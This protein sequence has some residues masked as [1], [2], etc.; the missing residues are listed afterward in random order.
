MRAEAAARARGFGTRKPLVL[1][2]LGIAVLA[3]GALGW[4]GYASIAGAVIASGH[5][6]VE[7]R[8]QVVEHI[9]GGMVGEILVRN[10]D[11]V[12]VGDVLVR[13][14][15]TILR[16]EEAILAAEYAELAARRNRLEAEFRNAD[17][18]DWDPDIAALAETD[19]AV[20]EILGGQRRLFEARARA[21]DGEAAQLR[22]RINQIREQIRG[23]R[24]QAD[25]LDRQ[26]ALV[27][28]ELAAQQSLYDRGMTDL[29]KVLTLKRELASLDGQAG[30]VAAGIARSHGRIAEIEIELL[31]IATRRIEEAEADA[32]ETQARQ[33]QVR[34]QLASVRARL[35]RLEVRAPVAGEVFGMTVFAVSS[36]VRPGDPIL[37]IIPNEAPLMVRAQL[38]PIHVDQ[39]HRGQE[40]VLRFS[41]FSARTTP[42]FEGRVERVSADVMRDPQ[43]GLSWYEMEIAMGGPFEHESTMELYER[44]QGV[45]SWAERH[46]LAA[47]PPEWRPEASPR[48]RVAGAAALRDPSEKLA[49]TPGMPVEVHIRT[50]ERSPLSY[51]VKPL[52]DYFTRSLREE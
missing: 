38:D 42:E 34:E 49:L 24:M 9:D 45:V 28:Q 30:G 21:L 35:D 18:I 7:T 14:D 13:F 37:H 12:V 1:G 36:V 26:R 25:A 4:G 41:S 10:G 3:A 33:N 19:A 47:L 8:N 32:R 16:T 11:I 50:G 15:D 40:A 23:V 27:G 22:E 46:I 2:F 6:E 52:A 29:R 48:P 39:V 17:E 20:R 51:L 5:V 44:M 31:Q 43:T